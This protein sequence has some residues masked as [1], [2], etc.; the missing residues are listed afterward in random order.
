MGVVSDI[1]DYSELQSEEI[2][3]EESKMVALEKEYKGT[4]GV[5]VEEWN[6]KFLDLKN[7]Q[8]M[9]VR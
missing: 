1:L 7:L 3:L 6:K 8:L 2:E 5:S 4:G 9:L